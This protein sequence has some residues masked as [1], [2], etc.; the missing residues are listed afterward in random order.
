MFHCPTC[1]ELLFFDN[2]CCLG[3]GTTVAFD[4]VTERFAA[5]G[6]NGV[7]RCANAPLIGCNWRAAQGPG[8]LC[9]ACAYNHRVPPFAD[10]AA[11]GSWSELEAAKRRLL[12]Q[13]RRL[14]GLPPTRAIDPAQGLGFDFLATAAEG[15][16][17]TTGHANGLITMN[18]AEG[19][20]A[21]REALRVQ[22]GERY[23]TALGHF[24]HEVGH[25]YWMRWG[26]RAGFLDAFRATF[27]DEREDYGASLQRHY[28]EGPPPDWADAYLTAYATAHPWED[29][30]E[31][32][33]HLLHLLASLESAHALGMGF[34]MAQV[35][36]FARCPSLPDPYHTAPADFPQLLEA[37]YRVSCAVNLLNRSVGQPDLY[38]FAINQRARVK[39]AFIF[40]Q[41]AVTRA[42]WSAG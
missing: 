38:P 11:C 29:F 35:P 20:P 19:D 33:A 31:T 42:G 34:P 40:S 12:F 9:E 17:V 8:S 37:W 23:R 3:C 7:E 39:L 14:G 28:A 30:A 22:L 18:V 32:F 21:T 25:Y 2:D 36:F 16:P 5:L 26:A 6:Q 10:A 13:L 27:G 4:P 41:F 24:R 15:S 1:H